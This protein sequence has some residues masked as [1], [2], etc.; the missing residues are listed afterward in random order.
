MSP[1]KKNIHRKGDVHLSPQKEICF[2]FHSTMQQIN[3]QRKL[4]NNKPQCFKDEL[5]QGI[6]DIHNLERCEFISEKRMNYEKRNEESK[7][8]GRQSF[9]YLL[10]LLILFTYFTYFYLF[11][12]FTYSR[13]N[14]NDLVQGS[15][16]QGNHKQAKA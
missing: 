4:I 15:S 6:D 8:T 10:M 12:L 14:P 5:E 11:Y 16:P 13:T 2:C 9:M 3:I 7:R 1:Q